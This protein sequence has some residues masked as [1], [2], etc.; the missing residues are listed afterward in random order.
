M[1]DSE[2]ETQLD[3]IRIIQS[4]EQIIFQRRFIEKTKSLAVNIGLMSGI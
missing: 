2:C 4:S 3:R 1:F